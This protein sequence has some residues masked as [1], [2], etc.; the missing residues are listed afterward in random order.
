M[1]VDTL[2]PDD[3]VTD[4]SKIDTDTLNEMR[5]EINDTLVA[6][7]APRPLISPTVPGMPQLTEEVKDMHSRYFAIMFVLYSRG[8]KD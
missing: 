7:G 3:G 5:R 1:G 6:M 8:I 2:D 4:F